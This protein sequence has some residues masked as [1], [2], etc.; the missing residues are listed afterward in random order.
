LVFGAVGSRSEQPQDTPALQTVHFPG[1]A[2]LD[3]AN[4]SHFT[5]RLDLGNPGTAPVMA[6]ITFTPLFGGVVPSAATR[7]I[8]P[9]STQRIDAVLPTLFGVTG[10]AGALRIVS[11]GDVAASLTTSN[12]A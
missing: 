3:G 5:S 6:Q 2:E 8:A 1:V 9:G 7:V 12:V 4:G 10:T 11:D